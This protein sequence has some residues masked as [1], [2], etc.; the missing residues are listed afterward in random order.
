MRETGVNGSTDG[1]TNTPQS[2]LV[3]SFYLFII[4][5]NCVG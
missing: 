5:L 4:F 1:K 3:D 2:M